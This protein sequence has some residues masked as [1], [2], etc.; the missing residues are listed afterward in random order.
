MINSKTLK[1]RMLVGGIAAVL[2]PFFIIGLIV[3][4]QLSKSLLALTMERAVHHV[5]DAAER[6]ETV[7]KQKIELARSIA[8]DPDIIAA[9]RN[10]AYATAQKELESIYQGIGRDYF[11]IFLLDQ[12]GIARA[13]ARFPRQIGTD[14]SDRDYFLKAKQ[15]RANVGGPLP[16]RGSATPGASVII[17]SAPILDKGRFYGM[18]GIPFNN[19]FVVNSLAK[20]EFGTTGFT[21]LINAE[22]VVLMH[23]QEAYN[24]KLRFLDQPGTESIKRL[25]EAKT[26][27]ATSYRINRLEKIAGLAHVAATGWT[28][29]FSQDRQEAMAPMTK[30]LSLIVICAVAFCIVIIVAI[31]I[32]TNRISMNLF[33]NAVHAIADRCGTITLWA[34]DFMVDEEFAQTHPGI[35]PGNHLRLAVADTGGGIAPHLQDQIF[36]PFFTTKSQGEGTGLG[37]SVVHGII[38]KI[39]GIITVSSREGQGTRFDIVIPV[40]ESGDAGEGPNTFCL[41]PGNASIA[42][43]DDEETIAAV[44]RA[45]LS[46]VGYRVTAFTDGMAALKALRSDPEAFDVV[47]TDYAMPQTTGLE[48]AKALKESGIIIPMIIITGYVNET[49]EK[50]ARATGIAELI[51]KPINAYQLTD[52]IQ[53]VL[54]KA[55]V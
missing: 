34:E 32:Y 15:G 16:A 24:F 3:Y 44:I 53:R 21:F 54:A 2:I 7:L 48:I 9:S 22:G 50:A 55:I 11:T 49:I 41:T 19:D 13:D 6:I 52:A 8:A 38:S 1:T 10:G 51:I 45:I 5:E 36:L 23:P 33:T 20:G 43:I 47:I 27:G 31:N 30:I 35:R 18:V 40:C 46:N 4:G 14:L 42:V 12:N 17:V 28:V 39:G 26:T 29:V 25:A 37:L